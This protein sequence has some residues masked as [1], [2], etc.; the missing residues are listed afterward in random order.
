[1]KRLQH[2]NIVL[3]FNDVTLMPNTMRKLMFN[4][5]NAYLSRNFQEN[6]LISIYCDLAHF[7]LFFIIGISVDMY[8][9]Q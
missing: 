5:L 7:F 2:D 3:K 9:S 1:M 4:M 8:I 6:V